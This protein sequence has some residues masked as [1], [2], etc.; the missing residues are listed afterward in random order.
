[1]N[2]NV[3][4]VVNKDANG[5]LSLKTNTFKNVSGYTNPLMVS[6]SSLA[7]TGIN[8]SVAATTTDPNAAAATV[9]QCGSASTPVSTDMI[10]RMGICSIQ[11]TPLKHSQQNTRLYVNGYTFNPTYEKLYLENPIRTI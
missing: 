8:A 1:M 3:E 10:V 9:I 5:K 6:A 2:T 7:L 4:F 11:G